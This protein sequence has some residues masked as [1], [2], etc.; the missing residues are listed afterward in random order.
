MH[1]LF[2][3][4]PSHIVTYKQTALSQQLQRTKSYRF[5]F[6]SALLDMGHV[7][8]CCQTSAQSH[9]TKIARSRAWASRHRVRATAVDHHSMP[10]AGLRAF[11]ALEATCSLGT[12]RM[13]EAPAD[14]AQEPSGSPRTTAQEAARNINTSLNPK[15]VTHSLYSI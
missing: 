10:G 2:N 1:L 7:A 15:L 14:T 3:S 12:G 9:V 5:G 13:D 6:N 8:L 11:F 4:E